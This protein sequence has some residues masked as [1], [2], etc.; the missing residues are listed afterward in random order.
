MTAQNLSYDSPENLA[1]MPAS[2]I[3]AIEILI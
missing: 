1:V 3:F 2:R